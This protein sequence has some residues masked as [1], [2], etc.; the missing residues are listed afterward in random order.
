MASMRVG[1]ALTLHPNSPYAVSG[2]ASYT[3][4]LVEA[5]TGE[6]AAGVTLLPIQEGALDAWPPREFG[7][8]HLHPFTPAGEQL[9]GALAETLRRL[10]LDVVHV[11][12]WGRTGTILFEACMRAQLP[13]V[14]TAVDYKP[15]CAQSQLLRA[16]VEVCSGP[17][18]AAKCRSCLAALG[19]P[20]D[21]LELRLRQ[22]TLE[23]YFR[24][25][26]RLVTFTAAHVDELD[27]WLQLGADRYAVVPFD[28]PAAGPGFAKAA[29]AFQRPL[30]FA[31]VARTCHEWGIGLLVEAWR[32]AGIDPADAVLEVHTDE[33][34]MR[35]GLA[36]AARDLIASGAVQVTIGPAVDRIDEIHA[37]TAAVVV[38]SQW[39]NT[40]SSSAMEALA[41]ATPV[42]TAN[43]Y[44]VFQGLPPEQQQLAYEM[45]D[46]DALAAALRAAIA[47]P[48]RLEAAGRAGST[49]PGFEDHVAALADIYARACG[50]APPTAAWAPI[51]AEG[52]RTLLLP[53]DATGQWEAVVS[54]WITRAAS[55][56]AWCLVLAPHTIDG[57][58]VLQRVHACI[59]AAGLDPADI[60]DLLV[61][62]DL[63]L[64]T[65]LAAVVASCDRLLAGAAEVELRAAAAAAAVPVAATIDELISG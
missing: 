21:E 40:G 54:D 59:A 20:A 62:P 60:P 12:D 44:G 35:S 57:A 64:A 50:H 18:T 27:R 46:V 22:R 14:V 56:A 23:Y 7:A 6:P 36:E 32:R 31:Y 9:V 47:A 17:E 52:L 63:P 24:R 39:K 19:V 13:Y 41:R 48:D 42:I 11:T 4:R 34:W 10:E 58:Q 15:I 51:D 8:P 61:L 26:E 38:P 29:D 5:F 2:Y 43:R 30:H 49:Q 55:V 45:G 16:G 25:A 53:C 1:L 37:H 3:R 28:V 65:E 33:G